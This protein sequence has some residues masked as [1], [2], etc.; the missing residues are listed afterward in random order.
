MEA[1]NKPNWEKKK[2]ETERY[3]KERSMHRKIIVNNKEP[4]TGLDGIKIS[5]T[6]RKTEKMK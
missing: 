2:K 5:R 3:T 1:T 4:R 6:E